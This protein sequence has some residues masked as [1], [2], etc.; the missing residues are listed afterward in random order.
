MFS[1]LRA[2]FVLALALI[3]TGQAQSSTSA[4]VQAGV[5]TGK[6]IPGNY[7]GA[8]RPQI[9]FSPPQWFMVSENPA[10]LCAALFVLFALARPDALYASTVCSSE[11]LHSEEAGTV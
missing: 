10:M 5:P 11:W 9:H 2:L 1:N 4:Y 7:T 8:L 6:P 3:S